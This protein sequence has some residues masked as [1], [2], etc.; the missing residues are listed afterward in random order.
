MM[1][2]WAVKK[3]LEE[4][5]RWAL[6]QQYMIIQVPHTIVVGSDKRIQIYIVKGAT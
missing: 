2:L 6:T 3:G 1:L 5:V 4:L